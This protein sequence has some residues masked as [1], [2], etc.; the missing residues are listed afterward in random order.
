MAFPALLEQS[1]PP[2]LAAFEHPIAPQVSIRAE[3][4]L[5]SKEDLG[6]HLLRLVHQGGILRQEG[7]PLGCVGF[8]QTLFGPFQH[9]S[10]AVQSLPPCRRA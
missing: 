8:E 10:Q 5:V 6:P 2:G 3:V 4:G 9:K 7:L 1:P